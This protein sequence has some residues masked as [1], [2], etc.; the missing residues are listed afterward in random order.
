MKTLFTVDMVALSKRLIFPLGVAGGITALVVIL[1]V[2]PNFGVDQRC[3][4]N[5]EWASISDVSGFIITKPYQGALPLQENVMTSGRKPDLYEFVIAPN[6][7]GYITMVYDT[8]SKPITA[9]IGSNLSQLFSSFDTRRSG[10]NKFDSDEESESFRTGQVIRLSG[11]DT[12]G[13]AIYPSAIKQEND[14]QV[15]VTYT[16]E[17]GSG[18]SQGLYIM[19]LYHTCPGQLLTVGYKPYEGDI[20]WTNGGS[21]GCSF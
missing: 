19:N 6:S 13:L 8:C 14:H 3:M 10:I 12:N 5:N 15:H 4:S 2:F 9:T 1:L 16:I 20:P 21:Y 17:A 18:M 7:T 11:S